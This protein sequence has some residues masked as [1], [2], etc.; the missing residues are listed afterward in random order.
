M[1]PIDN[2]KEFKSVIASSNLYQGICVDGLI[3]SSNSNKDNKHLYIIGTGISYGTLDYHEWNEFTLMLLSEFQIITAY[4]NIFGIG[5]LRRRQIQKTD[6]GNLLMEMI[7][8]SEP[9]TTINRITNIR[10]SFNP[11]RIPIIKLNQVVDIVR[12]PTIKSCYTHIDI[13]LGI[14]FD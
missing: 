4:I 1:E 10:K 9:E 5:K 8:V 6:N 13:N 7:N 12:I 3:V 14:T 2:K 11:T